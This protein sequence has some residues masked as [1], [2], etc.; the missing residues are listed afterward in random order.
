MLI[1]GKTNNI[2]QNGAFELNKNDKSYGPKRPNSFCDIPI[3]YVHS[4]H[5]YRHLS[6]CGILH[7]S[8]I[9]NKIVIESY[10]LEFVFS[11]G[12]PRRAMVTVFWILCPMAV[13]AVMDFVKWVKNYFNGGKQKECWCG[14]YAC[15]VRK[16]KNSI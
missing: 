9:L 15:K 11:T 1:L 8:P 4:G 12:H 13:K 7:V 3:I 5:R 2:F 6:S 14:L 16:Y 10:Q